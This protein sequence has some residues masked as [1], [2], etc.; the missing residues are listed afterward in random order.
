VVD[1]IYVFEITVPP[2]VPSTAPQT[3]ACA[4]PPRDIAAIDV[5]VPPGFN[6]KVGFQIAAAGQ[7]QIPINVGAFVVTNDEE[8][9][10]DWT[11]SVNSGA[12]QVLA[13]NIGTYPHTFEVRFR[14][15]LVGAHRATIYPQ[16][17]AIGA[18]A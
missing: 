8:I 17:L 3:F 11:N 4:M 2:G 13:Y 1:E 16:P 5:K 9:S 15:N 18:P 10:W 7:Q 6:G 14:V 12:W